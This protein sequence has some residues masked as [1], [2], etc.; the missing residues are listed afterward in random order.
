MTS[1]IDQRDSGCQ[2]AAGATSNWTSTSPDRAALSS[3]IRRSIVRSRSTVLRR[4]GSGCGDG[5]VV[6]RPSI[7]VATSTASRYRS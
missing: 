5:W 2:T 1:P 3:R 4:T 6:T 7:S